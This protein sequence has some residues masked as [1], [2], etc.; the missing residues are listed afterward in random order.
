[1]SDDVKKYEISL[2]LQN[3]EAYDDIVSFIKG[4]VSE[5][6]QQ[7][8]IKRVKLAY[9]I[10]KETT[11][12]FGWIVV[13][14][15]PSVIPGLNRE[16]ET[17]VNVLRVLIVTPPLPIREEGRQLG[18][19]KFTKNKPNRDESKV[20]APQ[21]VSEVTKKT[22]VLTNELLEKKLEEILK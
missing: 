7:N 13:S 12:F 15:A 20:I 22:E 19:E 11:G 2:M 17:N 9:P 18:R 5:V 21:Q 6:L 8:P 1:M 10:K 4:K 3:G 14:A 16:L